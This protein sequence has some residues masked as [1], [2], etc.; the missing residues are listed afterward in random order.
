MKKVIFIL[1]GMIGLLPFFASCEKESDESAALLGSWEL[2]SAEKNG[3]VVGIDSGELL[4]FTTNGVCYIYCPADDF[5]LRT[6]WNYEAEHKILN[7]ADLLPVTFYVEEVGRGK[8]TLK[9]YKYADDGELDTYIK[10]Y[11]QVETVLI[12]GK[13]RLAQ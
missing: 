7:I 5:D 13:L 6:A 10:V 4:Y 1:F 9:Y 3:V 8:L 11:K 12:D 2:V